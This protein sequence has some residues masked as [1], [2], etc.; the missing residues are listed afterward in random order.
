M[1]GVFRASVIYV[2]CLAFVQLC[3]WFHDGLVHFLLEEYFFLTSN[4]PL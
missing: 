4:Y 3:E 1:G 2:Q